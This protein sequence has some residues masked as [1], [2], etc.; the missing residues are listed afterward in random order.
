MAGGRVKGVA[1]REFVRWYSAQYGE[2]AVLALAQTMSPE[3]RAL[4]N[5]KA[6]ILG[7]VSSEW[8]P[9]DGIH[10]VLDHM[11]AGRSAEERERIARDGAEAVISET[12][13]GVYKL[14]FDLMVSPDR[15]LKNAQR[16]FSRFF[17]EGVM[18]K[19]ATGKTE[20]TSVIR[21]WPA[22]HPLFCTFLLHIS[23]YVYRA[24]GLKEVH[25]EKLRCV[26]DGDRDCAYRIR[27]S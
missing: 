25:S 20:H 11:V 6:P 7:L 26:S 13:H 19:T 1:I 12:L 14:F 27:W 16:L 24:M 4:I 17:D 2:E 23:E 3:F 9:A 10:V 18:E 21:D 8:Y 5:V 22:H 15:Y